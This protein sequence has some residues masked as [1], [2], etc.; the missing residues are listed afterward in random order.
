MGLSSVLRS[1]GEP[2]AA[3]L[4][5]T[6][7]LAIQPESTVLRSNRARLALSMGR[8]AEA[9]ADARTL[10]EQVPED[11]T[12]RRILLDAL[13]ASHPGRAFAQLAEWRVNGVDPVFLDAFQGL[14]EL[15]A[16]RTDVAAD[17]LQRAAASPLPP[18]GTHLG[19]ASVATARGQIPLA[20]WHLSEEVARFPD[21]RTARRTLADYL[22][23]QQEWDAAATHYRRLVGQ[24]GADRDARR[25]WAQAALNAGRAGRAREILEPALASEDPHVLALQANVLAALGRMGEARTVFAKAEAR[26]RRTR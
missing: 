14:L 10:I 8:L 23:A 17:L 16:Q 18:Q 19:L 1:L 9:E 12:A 5:L 20:G 26:I 3:L 7:A 11:E 13:A 21:D 4:V 15:R 2:E 22:M 25:A 6:D 24:A